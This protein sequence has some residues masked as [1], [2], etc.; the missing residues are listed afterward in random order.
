MFPPPPEAR[1]G[2][3]NG[4]ESAIEAKTHLPRILNDAKMQTLARCARPWLR[5]VLTRM[6]RLNQGWT[7]LLAIVER[8]HLSILRVSISTDLLGP[9]NFFQIQQPLQQASPSPPRSKHCGLK[10]PL[11]AQRLSG[12]ILS[13]SQSPLFLPVPIFQDGFHPSLN[14]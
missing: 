14:F 10:C 11:M 4:E 1:G 12:R 5:C 2:E 9:H 13:S 7:T 3:A 8:P 6:S